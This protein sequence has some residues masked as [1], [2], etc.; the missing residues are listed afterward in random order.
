[1]SSAKP[2]CSFHHGCNSDVR[3]VRRLT[4][5]RLHANRVGKWRCRELFSPG[6]RT[7]DLSHSRQ[8][9]INAM[10]YSVS[11]VT[12]I[13][14]GETSAL[15]DTCHKVFQSA[16]YSSVAVPEVLERGT[17]VATCFADVKQLV[18]QG[19]EE[20]KGLLREDIEA[21]EGVRR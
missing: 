21:S 3:R 1:M 15:L 11:R 14:A 20:T 5:V 17:S 8:S 6:R 2:S 16:I 13:P 19:W 10:M 12:E 9:N 7:C 18:R 4:F